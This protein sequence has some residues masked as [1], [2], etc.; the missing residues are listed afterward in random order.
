V[1]EDSSEKASVKEDVMETTI[2]ARVVAKS[3]AFPDDIEMFYHCL[4]DRERLTGK[5]YSGVHFSWDEA[6]RRFLIDKAYAE[7]CEG[8]F[9]NNEAAFLGN[10]EVIITIDE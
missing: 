10:R 5:T 7:E 2:F 3:V 9:R 8:Y 6:K 4:D 1:A